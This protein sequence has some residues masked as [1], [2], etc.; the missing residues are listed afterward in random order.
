M[1][2][3]I[4]YYTYEIAINK[5]FAQAKTYEDKRYHITNKKLIII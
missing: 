5:K 2:L 3:Q 4:Q 1:T